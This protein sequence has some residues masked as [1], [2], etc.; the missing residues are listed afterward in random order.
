MRLEAEEE[1]LA[2]GDVQ[3]VAVGGLGRAGKVVGFDHG[4]LLF[5]RLFLLGEQLLGPAGQGGSH[6][7]AENQKKQGECFS[8][9]Q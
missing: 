2:F 8:H 9:L 3:L 7:Q 5:G 4:F 1:W 6:K